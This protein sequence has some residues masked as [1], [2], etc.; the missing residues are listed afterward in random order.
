M[1]MAALTGRKKGLFQGVRYTYLK[2]RGLVYLEYI[3]LFFSIQIFSPDR[4]GPD[5]ICFMENQRFFLIYA[6]LCI[7]EF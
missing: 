5:R 4:T 7:L 3:Y 2:N 6:E 1:A